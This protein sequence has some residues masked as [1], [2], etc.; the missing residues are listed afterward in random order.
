[1][2]T[3]GEQHRGDRTE[4]GASIASGSILPR[5]NRR[6]RDEQIPRMKTFSWGAPILAK[7]GQLGEWHLPGPSRITS[8]SYKRTAMHLR[9]LTLVTFAAPFLFASCSSDGGSSN[10]MQSPPVESTPNQNANPLQPPGAA[11]NSPAAS[12]DTASPGGGS[13]A[14]NS[15][16]QV[17]TETP[18]QPGENP[19]TTPGNTGSP[20]PVV[21]VEGGGSFVPVGTVENR[22]VDC[23]VGALPAGNTL[24]R[25]PNLP[26]PFTKLEGTRI[27][28]K[29]DW[30][31]Q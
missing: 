28:K 20:G 1:M 29:S 21:P 27:T 24:P 3:A 25:S 30:V 22:G 31:C 5:K 2:S 4:T 12:P 18:L 10:G 11:D 14:D 7:Y 9:R 26:D 6:P 15:E 13:T 19:G 23:Q 17:G 8:S 16:G